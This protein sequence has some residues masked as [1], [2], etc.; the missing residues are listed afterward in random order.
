MVRYNSR[1]K[2]DTI[3]IRTLGRHIKRQ[4]NLKVSDHLQSSQKSHGTGISTKGILSTQNLRHYRSDA[5]VARQVCERSHDCMLVA[6][7]G[8]T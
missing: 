7:S 6:I 8:S 3:R 1:R 2:L 5:S 4:V